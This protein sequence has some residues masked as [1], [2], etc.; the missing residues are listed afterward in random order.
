MTGTR[1][2]NAFVDAGVNE[3]THSGI[4]EILMTSCMAK[5]IVAPLPPSITID[6]LHDGS[7]RYPIKRPFYHNF[8]ARS[9]RYLCSA[10]ACLSCVPGRG[11]V[12]ECFSS[13]EGGPRIVD[14]PQ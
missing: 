13:I 11:R 3:V 7:H 2:H 1:G 10:N 8:A 5:A 12:R 14:Y 6:S 4:Y 9:S